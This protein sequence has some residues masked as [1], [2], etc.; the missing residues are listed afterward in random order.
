[1]PDVNAIDQFLSTAGDEFTQ[2]Y[3]TVNPPPAQSAPVTPIVYT[4]ASPAGGAA[5]GVDLSSLILIVG[6]IVGVWWLL[7]K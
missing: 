5:V 4:S 2:I 1:M 6:V 3:Q 7:R